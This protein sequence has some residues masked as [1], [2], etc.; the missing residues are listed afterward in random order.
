MDFIPDKSSTG[1]EPNVAA[2][3]S[4]IFGWVSGLI[5]FLIEKESKF[6]KFWAFQAILLSVV[7]IVLC[8]I[9]FVNFVGGPL[10]LV[11]WIISLIKAFSGKVHKWPVIGEVAA[12][13]AGL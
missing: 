5:F 7:G 8:A 4:V 9:P 11:L 1:M 13:Q 10:F 3:V 2:G 12:K 6:V